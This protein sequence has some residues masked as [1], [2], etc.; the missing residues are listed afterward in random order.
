MIVP[1]ID[2]QATIKNLRQRTGSDDVG[3]RGVFGKQGM[4]KEY[5]GD[6]DIEGIATTNDIDSSREVVVP[7][8]A[9][10][11]YFIQNKSI[12]VDHNYTVHH[13][14]GKLRVNSLQLV[15]G[16]DGQPYGWRV[17][18][19]MSKT[20]NQ[21]LV[22]DCMGLARDG[23]GMSIGFRAL[24]WGAPSADETKRWPNAVTVIRKWQW[25]ELSLTP[26]PCNVSCRGWAMDDPAENQDAYS[27]TAK[28]L[29]RVGC[30]Q[31]W[32]PPAPVVVPVPESEPEKKQ[33]DKP[34]AR[35]VV[36]LR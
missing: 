25:L 14:V 23:I 21:E 31:L 3:I 8:G 6:Y 30:K 11:T 29:E 32:R 19:A 9:D 20:A 34:K 27:A 26:F 13:C 12:F 1:T 35:T 16:I 18:I 10:V 15:R 17:R 5:G 33:V 36:I 7:E 4:A 24:D 28:C 2:I 22:R